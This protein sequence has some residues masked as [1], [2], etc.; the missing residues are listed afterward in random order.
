MFEYLNKKL[1]TVFSSAHGPVSRIDNLL[2]H[3]TSLDKFKKTEIILSIF[4][5]HNGMKLE[6]NYRK[7]T[8]KIRNMWTLNMLLNNQLINE[9]IKEEI[10]K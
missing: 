2:G 9:E 1:I 3:K 6:I 8:G 7:K 5:N 10:K 4:S